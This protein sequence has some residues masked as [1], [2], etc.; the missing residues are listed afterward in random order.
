VARAEAE[1]AAVDPSR[2][3]A[4]LGRVLMKELAADYVREHPLAKPGELE[5]RLLAEG[6]LPFRLLRFQMFD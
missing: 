3:S 4:G 1:L 2:A 5:E 6:L